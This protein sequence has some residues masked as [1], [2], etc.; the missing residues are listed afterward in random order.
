MVGVDLSSSPLSPNEKSVL[1]AVI[2]LNESMRSFIDLALCPSIDLYLSRGRR[3][4]GDRPAGD[5]PG[6]RGVIGDIGD[7]VPPLP[8]RISVNFC[9][10]SG[11]RGDRGGTDVSEDTSTLLLLLLLLRLEGLDGLEKSVADLDGDTTRTATRLP[12]F[13]FSRKLSRSKQS[14]EV[15]S[16][17]LL[18]RAIVLLLRLRRFSL[19]LG[20]DDSSGFDELSA[21][22]EVGLVPFSESRLLRRGQE[23][24][25][26]CF[27]APGVSSLSF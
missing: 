13:S 26:G 9:F 19:L 3:R 10:V 23:R 14:F 25:R 6:D 27:L 18:V 20:W 12:L 15:A 4:R 21:P 11:D 17:L 5:R 22:R 1:A 2:V 8:Q 16:W 7:F 24:P